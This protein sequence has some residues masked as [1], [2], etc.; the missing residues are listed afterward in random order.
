MRPGFSIVL[1]NGTIDLKTGKTPQA[2][3]VEDLC[4]KRLHIPF[5]AQA[6]VRLDTFLWRI[7]GVLELMQIGGRNTECTRQAG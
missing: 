5:D 6:L 3:E 7:M 1:R 2:S 4:T